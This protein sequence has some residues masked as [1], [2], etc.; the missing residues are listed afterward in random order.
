ML[1]PPGQFQIYYTKLLYR[2]DTLT[3]VMLVASNTDHTSHKPTKCINGSQY[4]Y[5]ASCYFA[6]QSGNP[7]GTWYVSTPLSRPNLRASSYT[8]SVATV[9]ISCRSGTGPQVSVS[10]GVY[11]GFLNVIICSQ[12]HLFSTINPKQGA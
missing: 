12:L 5:S 2:S 8:D 11:R 3:L 10:F 7:H 1:S 6:D 4:L 9:Q